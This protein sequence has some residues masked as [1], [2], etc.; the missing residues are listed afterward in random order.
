MAFD[1][2]TAAQELHAS[3]I[4]TKQAEAI[5]RAIG[6]AQSIDPEQVATKAELYRALWLQGAGI[7]TL[8]TALSRLL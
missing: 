2:L 5:A 3:G 7:V 1:T 4:E 8:V 6:Q